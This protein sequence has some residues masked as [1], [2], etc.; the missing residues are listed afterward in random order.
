[1]VLFAA[2]AEARAR[3]VSEVLATAALVAVG[4]VLAVSV[5]GVF[6]QRVAT[7]AG[8]AFARMAA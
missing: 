7:P 5:P 6:T 3:A 4:P 2:G 8:D 1:L